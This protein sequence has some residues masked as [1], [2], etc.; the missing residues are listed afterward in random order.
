M[1]A[2]VCSNFEVEYDYY[3]EQRKIPLKEGGSDI[4]ITNDNRLEFVELFTKWKLH[5]SIYS[6]FGAFADGFLEVLFDIQS[7]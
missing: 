1:E 5:D 3:G 6:Q 2:T 4:P 7:P